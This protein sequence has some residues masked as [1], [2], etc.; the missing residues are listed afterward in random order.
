MIRNAMDQRPAF[1]SG[2]AGLVST[3]DDYAR[4]ATMLLQGGAYQGRRILQPATVAYMTG[5]RLRPH[6]QAAMNNWQGLEGYTYAN[7]MRILDRPGQAVCLAQAGVWMG[8][9]AGLLL[10]Q[11]AR[12]PVDL[13]VDDP[14]DRRG[15]PCP[16]PARCETA[17]WRSCSAKRAQHL[18]DR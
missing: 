17:F 12:Q 9:V 8:W 13:S 18:E 1:E 5:G 10:R 7:F 14:G 11:P 2:G 4:L 16:S 15:Y 6:Q 3:V